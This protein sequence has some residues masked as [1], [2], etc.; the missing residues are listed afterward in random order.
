MQDDS[1]SGY[2]ITGNRELNEFQT[3]YE[4]VCSNQ[5]SRFVAGANYEGIFKTSFNMIKPICEYI[6]D[7]TL[8]S[9]FTPIEQQI[10]SIEP[11]D[12]ILNSS[13]TDLPDFSFAPQEFITQV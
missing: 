6:H 13:G 9:V 11:T 5:N 7:T 3:L 1:F 2:Q 8:A 10:K 4:N 12:S